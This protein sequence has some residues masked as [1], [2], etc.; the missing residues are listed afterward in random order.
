M[1]SP[2]WRKYNTWYRTACLVCLLPLTCFHY[3]G[4]GKWH[5]SCLQ[6]AFFISL[7][8]VMSL[9]SIIALIFL[10]GGVILIMIRVLRTSQHHFDTDI[11]NEPIDIPA[12]SGGGI[13]FRA[14]VH[15]EKD[16][17]RDLN[18]EVG[19][20]GVGLLFCAVYRSSTCWL[21][22]HIYSSNFEI[23]S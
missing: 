5:R 14:V 16:C 18:E 17:L 23:K 19:G 6:V 7:E 22:V 8:S 12:S 20:K 13:K 11:Q 4:S 3:L 15:S 21:N 10:E 2:E 9:Q 1:I